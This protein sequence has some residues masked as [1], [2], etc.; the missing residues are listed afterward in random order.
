MGYV[1]RCGGWMRPQDSRVGASRVTAILWDV[2]GCPYKLV[3]PI[4]SGGF[5]Q[6][7]RGVRRDTGLVAAIKIQKDDPL[8]MACFRREIDV[9]RRLDHPHVM[10]IIEAD[11]AGRWYAMALADY[12]LRQLHDRNPLDWETLREALSSV[13]GAMLHMHAQGLVHRDASPDNVLC[14]PNRHWVLAD[15]GPRTPPA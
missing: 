10:A 4:G 7:F 5:A 9:L 3:A 15:H 8:A 2:E 1:R 14:L 11:P 13:C 6:V 12:T